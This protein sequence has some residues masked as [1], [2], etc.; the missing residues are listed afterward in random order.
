MF[1][2][3]TRV[4]S[5][6]INYINDYHDTS[7]PLWEEMAKYSLLSGKALRPLIVENIFLGLNKNHT[8]FNFNSSIL[9]DLMVSIE[10]LHCASLLLDDLPCMD[11]DN[12][13]RGKPCFHIK[14]SVHQAKKIANKF[15]LDSI[16]L[17]YK[18][19]V[20]IPNVISIIINIIQD[21][22]IG[23]YIDLTS[24][25][26]F[27]NRKNSIEKCDLLCLKTS[28]LFSLAFSF[29]YLS[30]T[31]N[32]K[33]LIDEHEI[34]SKCQ[35]FIEIGKIFG[36]LYQISD[37]FED[38]IEDKLKGRNMNNVIVLGY[39]SCSNIFYSSKNELIILLNNENINYKVFNNFFGSILE[40]L[41]KKMNNGLV[42][43]LYNI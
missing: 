7:N 25:S 4:D 18:H 37:D 40:I 30:Y 22:A 12:T 41:S 35:V 38:Y 3:R 27:D 8:D 20:K 5:L 42:K 24:N 17:V 26:N 6:L 34:T 39:S 31:L 33:E 16:R 21:T 13:R 10:L 28:T 1:L 36:R 11:N 32:D 23:Q 29:G 19:I 43:V 14:Y 2:N 9:D 15:I